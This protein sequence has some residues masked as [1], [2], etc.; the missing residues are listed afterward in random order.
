MKNQNDQYEVMAKNME[1]QF[2]GYLTEQGYTV[3]EFSQQF[4]DIKDSFDQIFVKDRFEGELLD[5]VMSNAPDFINL[6]GDQ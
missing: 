1:E 4:Q 2:K 6:P 5:D 3:V